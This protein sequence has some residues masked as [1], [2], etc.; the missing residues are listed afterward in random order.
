M[1]GSVLENLTWEGNSKKMFALVM[2]AVPSIFSGL[3]K[4][5]IEDWIVKNNVNVVT[6]DLCLKMFKEKA[7]KGMIEKLTPKLEHLKT[8]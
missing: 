1:R 7:P 5:E 6:E 2:D 3:V 8:K 4:H